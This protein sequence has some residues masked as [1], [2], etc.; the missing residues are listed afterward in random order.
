MPEAR[1]P[2]GLEIADAKTEA[3]R[4]VSPGCWSQDGRPTSQTFKPRTSDGGLLSLTRGGEPPADEPDRLKHTMRTAKGA[5]EFATEVT[6]LK[7]L[8][9]M[10]VSVGDFNQ[11]A[12]GIHARVFADPSTVAEDGFDD[13]AH[14]VADYRALSRG[15]IDKLASALR[16]TAGSFSFAAPPPADAGTP[17]PAPS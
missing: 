14:L 2:R 15:Q 12:M 16:Q 13:L 8:G 4:Q 5:W 3:H 17:P 7:S 9:S 1:G 10:S 6:N 11:V